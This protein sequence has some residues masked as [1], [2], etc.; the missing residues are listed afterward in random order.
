[1]KF[2]ERVRTLREAR[3]LTQHVLAERMGVSVSYISKLENER[4][5]FGDYPFGEVHPQTGY[6]TGSRRR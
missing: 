4:L 5:H 3:L 1:M 6:R 2:G